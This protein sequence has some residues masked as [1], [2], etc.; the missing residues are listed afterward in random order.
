LLATAKSLSHR[1]HTAGLVVRSS[2]RAANALYGGQLR[3]LVRLLTAG[4]TLR[5]CFLLPTD[6]G[7]GERQLHRAREQ[8]DGGGG[9]DEWFEFHVVLGDAAVAS[10]IVKA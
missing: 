6:T 5:S 9:D 2:S 3:A 8:S 10:G 7:L 1:S 4:R